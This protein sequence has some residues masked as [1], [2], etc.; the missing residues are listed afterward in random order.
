[1]T[2][3]NGK[4][5]RKPRTASHH[6]AP[7]SRARQEAT[8]P[9]D[10]GG[11]AR[12]ADDASAGLTAAPEPVV[13]PPGNDGHTPDG[14]FAPGNGVGRRFEKGNRMGR[15][16]PTAIKMNEYR[17]A[18]LE[19]LDPRVIP[20][21]AGRLSKDALQGDLEATKV[22]LGY[23]MGRPQQAVE[24]S[25]PDGAELGINVGAITTVVL[26]ALSGPEHAEARVR[27]AA[28]LM[29]LD[30]ARDE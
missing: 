21:L 3:K 8:P 1:M 26:G 9:R 18:F 6:P 28:D 2:E 23:A 13:S 11:S 27:I 20:A 29:R 19:A 5:P 4:H 25:G 12:E 24:L 30:E 7:P 14:K 16:S 17:R 10:A 15:G 22:L